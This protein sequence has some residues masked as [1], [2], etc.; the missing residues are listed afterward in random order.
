MVRTYIDSEFELDNDYAP[1]LDQYLKFQFDDE[2]IEFIYFMIG[3]LMTRLNDK[4]D[5]MVLLYGE[6]GSG[7]SLL[8]NLLKY[9]FASDQ[10]IILSNSHQ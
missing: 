9:S 7:K 4:F 10:V 1:L 6:G 2:T 3:R 5:F 8:M